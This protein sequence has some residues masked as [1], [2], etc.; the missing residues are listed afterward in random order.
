VIRSIVAWS[1]NFRLLAV[2]IAA[3]LLVVGLVQLRG[4]PV[5]VLPE[6]TPPYVEIQTEALG[7]SASEVEQLITVPLERDLLNGVSGIDTIRSESVLGLSSVTLVFEPG[8]DLMNARQLVQERLLQSNLLP[9]VSMP[10]TMLQPLS[11]HSRVM[12][13]GLSSKELSLVDMGVLARWT[14]RPRLMG[15]PG[16]ANVVIWGHR[17]HEL[18]VLVDPDRLREQRVSLHQV[19]RTAG[20][21]QLVS[22]LSFLEAS[23]PGSGGFIDTPNQRLQVRHV[24]PIGKPAGLARVPVDAATGAPPPRTGGERMRLGDVTT[25]VEDHQPLI[26]DAVVD[27]RPGLLIAVEKFPGANTVEVTRGV[28]DALDAL[29]PGLSG[30]KIDPTVFRPASYIESAKENLKVALVVGAALL[31]VVLV[32]LLFE[33]RAALIALVVIP[34]SLLAATLVLALRGETMNAL[35]VAGLVVALA[36]VVDDAV[37]GVENVRRRL[38][39]HRGEDGRSVAAVVLEATLEMR[40]PLGY[41]TLIGLVAVLPVFFLSGRPGDFYEPVA[42]SY[43]LALVTSTAVALT[44]TP[45]FSFLLLAKGGE[46]GWRRGSAVLSR[47]TPRYGSVVRRV[48]RTPGRLLVGAGLVALVGLAITPFLGQSLVPSFQERDLLIRLEGVPGTSHPAMVRI[49]ARVSRELSS[50]PGVREVGAHVGRAVMGD[51]IVGTNSADVWVSLEPDSSYDATVDRVRKVVDGYPGLTGEL[52]SYSSHRIRAIGGLERGSL[53]GTIATDDLDALS[54]AAEPVVVRIYGKELGVIREKAA[55]VREVV[56]D[57]DGVVNA[58]VE[59]ELTEPTVE[60]AP[61]LVAAQRHGIKPGDIRRAAALLVQGITVGALFEEQ[62]VFDVVVR[63]VPEVRHSLSSVQNLPIDKPDGGH[64][65][66]ADVA[67]VRIAPGPTVIKREAVSRRLDVVA[68]VRGRALGHV[69]GD[70]EERLE[71]VDFPLEYHAEVLDDSSEAEAAG[72][73]LL[74]LAGAASLAILLLLQAAFVSWRLAVIFF[75]ALPTALF[76]GIVAA[77]AV[78]GRHLSL[79]A[80]AGLLTVFAIAVRNGVTLIDRYRHLRRSQAADFGPSLVLRGAQERLAPVLTA[81]AATLFVLAPFLVPTGIPGYEIFH[82]LA[83][84]VVGGLVTSTFFTLFLVPTLYLFFGSS[85]AAGEELVGD[86]TARIPA[87]ATESAPA[88]VHGGSHPDVTQPSEGR[89]E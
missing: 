29:R 79:G 42:L 10:P 68:D 9:N 63:G 49:S 45:A 28:E 11:S 31:L 21:A 60:V 56:A 70:V 40:R 32:A 61:D 84:V 26:G 62:K 27:D 66:L 30:M 51:R 15:V 75:V 55:E 69:L 64:V 52:M 22:P 44:L 25:I 6:F 38:E 81:A 73:R 57:V 16:V 5:D 53:S 77:L 13:V 46:P 3:L 78:D 24:L 71:H 23:T 74:M 19:V 80:A 4:M 34:L 58:R 50:L 54:G 37:V 36:I 47:L 67:N 2:P 7:L 89:N 86:L 88:G 83:V 18:Q 17:E 12:M 33:W 41:A 8:T 59:P 14:I 76:G 43:A 82:P 1:L 35:L 85:D 20:N 48:L 87:I 72:R 39:E 65:R